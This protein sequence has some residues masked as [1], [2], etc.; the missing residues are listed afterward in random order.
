MEAKATL[1]PKEQAQLDN[2]RATLASLNDDL[3]EL[4]ASMSSEMSILLNGDSYNITALQARKFESALKTLREF[5]GRTI[6]EYT[7]TGTQVSKISADEMARLN[8]AIADVNNIRSEV[9]ASRNLTYAQVNINDLLENIAA[10]RGANRVA[11]FA[12]NALF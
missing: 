6:Y 9:A 11:R 10:K 3:R 5:D 2:H 1:K 8:D 4:S 12:L 7:S